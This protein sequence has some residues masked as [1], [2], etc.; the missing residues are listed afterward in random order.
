[1]LELQYKVVFN[2]DADA[3]KGQNGEY[4]RDK[5][6]NTLRGKSAYVLRTPDFHVIPGSGFP[7]DNLRI[8]ACDD[9]EIRFSNKYDLS[10]RNLQKLQIVEIA[11][12]G[13]EIE[14]V[15]GGLNCTTDP[16]AKIPCLTADV[17]RPGDRG[18]PPVHRHCAVRRGVGR[19]ETLSREGPRH[20]TRQG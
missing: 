12:E 14:V 19:P 7:T 13:E 11:P 16:D 20:R 6:G 1:M 17:S 18:H 10:A 2:S 9:F 3:E 5:V 4:I 8:G 15:A